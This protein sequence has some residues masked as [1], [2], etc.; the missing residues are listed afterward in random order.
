VATS[1]Y[2]GFNSES[3]IERLLPGSPLGLLCSLV[4]SIWKTER[5]RRALPRGARTPLRKRRLFLYFATRPPISARPNLCQW[6]FCCVS[7][8]TADNQLCNPSISGDRP[9]SC[10]RFA[11]SRCAGSGS[12]ISFFS[13]ARSAFAPLRELAFGKSGDSIG[14]Y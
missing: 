10:I 4:C 1:A 6:Y 9:L 12:R 2:S 7:V 14:S 3:S 5:E 8:R 13:L 11:I